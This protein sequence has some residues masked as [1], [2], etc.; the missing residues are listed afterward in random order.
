MILEVRKVSI[1]KWFATEL[2]PVI[3]IQYQL[4][5][6]KSSSIDTPPGGFQI[7][8]SHCIIYVIKNEPLLFGGKGLICA[9]RI[10]SSAR[11]D[12]VLRFFT[13]LRTHTHFDWSVRTGVGRGGVPITFMFTCSHRHCTWSCRG[14]VGV[15]WGGVPL[16]FMFTCTQALHTDHA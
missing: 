3:I 14:G 7:G 1:C 11:K 13:R 2:F 9:H 16:T 4:Q 15:W 8:G 6:V 12:F 10:V 5:G